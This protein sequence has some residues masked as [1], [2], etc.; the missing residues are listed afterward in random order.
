MLR[1]FIGFFVTIGLIILLIIMIFGGGGDGN[2]AKVAKTSKPLVSYASTDS[3]VQMTIDGP[4]EADQT[5]KQV[6]ITVDKS[7]ARLEQING[8]DGSVTSSKDYVNN[9]SAYAN[10]L[11]ALGHA[12]FTAG[13]TSDTAV[14]DERGYCPQDNRYIFELKQGGQEIQRFW[15]SSCDKPRTYLGMLRLTTELF[16]KQI[17]NYD[18]QVSNHTSLY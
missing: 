14:K 10:F 17:P 18:D 12:G 2:K 13:D 16:E 1:Y 15:A 11:A 7:H 5:H 4:V 3:E 9:Q 8:Y 6:R